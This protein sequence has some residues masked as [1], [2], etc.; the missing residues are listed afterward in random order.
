MI[1]AN[2]VIALNFTLQSIQSRLLDVVITSQRRLDSPDGTAVQDTLTF[3]LALV[4]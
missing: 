3:S 4:N 2:D 1:I